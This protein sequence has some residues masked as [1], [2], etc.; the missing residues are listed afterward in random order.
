MLFVLTGASCSGKTEIATALTGARGLVVHDF[1]E[2]GVPA[3]PSTGWRQRSLERW[4]R[5][6]IEAQ[7]DGLDFLLSA[8]SPLGEVLAAPSADRLDAI[9][10]ALV[11]VD[12]AEREA[13]LE[14]RSPGVLDA[15]GRAAILDW[16]HW[17]RDHARDPRFEPERLTT[18]SARR[19][20][21][22]RWSDWREGDPRWVTTILDTTAGD[23]A[24]SVER[25]AE[26]MR[27]ARRARPRPLA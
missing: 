1:D 3:V 24:R 2:H 10:V 27:S 11:D 16:A 5:R 14:R 9:A 18:E 25:T 4:V 15:Q 22:D 8:P 7:H 13:R 19:M 26:W 12:D 23:V 20:R 17:H 6:A 21:W